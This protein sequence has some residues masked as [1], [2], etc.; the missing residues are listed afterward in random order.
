[1]KT[2]EEALEQF[3]L[4]KGTAGS[5]S[6]K[7]AC[8]TSLLGWIYYEKWTGD[9]LWC[10]HPLIRSLM[11]QHNDSDETTKEQRIEAVRLGMTGALDTWWIPAEVIL[12][13]FGDFKR[14]E[15]PT[16]NDHLVKMLTGVAAWKL[17]KVR[18][19][20]AGANLTYANLTY[21]TLAY[22]TLARAN[23]TGANLTYANLSGAYG[24]P[25]TL[26]IGWEY[27]N[28]LIVRKS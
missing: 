19:N 14:D 15:T 24:E 4:V 8:E 18:R 13:Y 12:S 21:A 25:R 11:I 6:E 9:S 22:A 3:E 27:K 17:D 23:L 10:A 1:M 7:K 5:E 20:L 28:G 16:Q 2:L 26:P